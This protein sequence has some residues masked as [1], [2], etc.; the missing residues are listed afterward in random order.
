[1]KIHR[2]IISGTIVLFFCVVGASSTSQLPTPSTGEWVG[3]STLP[4]IALL[5]TTL[6][7]IFLVIKGAVCRNAAYSAPY[8]PNLDPK[9]LG[10]YAFWVCYMVAMICVGDLVAS[11]DWL[12][13]PHNG[14]FIVSTFL[15]LLVA[16][17]LLGRRKP[18]E[19]AGIAAG[20]TA[21]LVLTFSGFF[22]VLLP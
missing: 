12:N 10:F 3:P 21:A 8:L 16:L 15:F 17:P 1:M 5:S 13:M 22:Q 7:G 4:Y 6:C 2:D 11:L 18:L 19:I 20:S 9:A 14:G